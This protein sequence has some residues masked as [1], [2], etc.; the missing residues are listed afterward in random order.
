MLLFIPGGVAPG[1]RTETIQIHLM[2]LFIQFN[3]FCSHSLE[4]S[5]TSHVIVYHY[6]HPLQSELLEFKYISCYCL[7]KKIIQKYLQMQIQIHL[8]L[9]FIRP[10]RQVSGGDRRF[11]YISCYCLSGSERAA[12][13]AGEKF[14][15]I[16]CY[17]LSS[18]PS[19]LGFESSHSNTSHVIVYLFRVF[20]IRI[21]SQN[22]NTSHVI[23]YHFITL[24]PFAD[25][26]I[27]IH[28][29]LLFILLCPFRAAS[30]SA[31]QIHLM[32]L[33]I[34]GD[35]VILNGK[36]LF[37]YISCYCLSAAAQ[38]ERMRA[39]HSNTSHVIVYL[40]YSFS[41]KFQFNIQIH[42]MLLFILLLL[43]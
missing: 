38:R 8:M 16:S 6:F 20:Q 27:Q 22:S 4:H 32:L 43:F 23:V 29:M 28:L 42:L 5:N 31:I 1:E 25:I 3:L 30:A 13:A 12:D 33:F 39:M 40:C 18:F 37:K 7:S 35:Y 26:K 36:R 41:H 14:K 11:K 24:V 21:T 10:E 34:N 9:L 2:L 17:C 19:A 15:Y